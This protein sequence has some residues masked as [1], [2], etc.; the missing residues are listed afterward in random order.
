MDC[1][2]L[3]RV[4]FIARADFLEIDHFILNFG[5]VHR[6]VGAVENNDTTQAVSLPAPI[7]DILKIVDARRMRVSFA[8]GAL[9]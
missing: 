9:V 7:T 5:V 6:R 2:L 8:I 3:V 4:M 1:C